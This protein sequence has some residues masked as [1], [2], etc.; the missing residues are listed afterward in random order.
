MLSKHDRML[1][2]DLKL[3]PLWLLWLQVALGLAAAALGLLSLNFGKS[4]WVCLG[5]G[6][7][8]ATGVERLVTRR[9]RTSA[10]RAASELAPAGREAG[11]VGE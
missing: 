2:A 11:G 10:T 8:V 1:R 9:I 6:F 3:Q 7:L 4:G 5:G